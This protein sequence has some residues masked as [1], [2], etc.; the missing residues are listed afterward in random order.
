M[1]KNMLNDRR[2]GVTKFVEVPCSVNPPQ[3]GETIVQ[4]RGT[5]TRWFHD[6]SHRSWHLIS[7]CPRCGNIHRPAGVKDTR[8]KK[9]ND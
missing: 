8:I 5:G 7:S 4:S 9:G 3:R 2:S 1:D 6:P